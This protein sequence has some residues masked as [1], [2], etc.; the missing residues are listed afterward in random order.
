MSRIVGVD[1]GGTKIAAALVAEDGTI[2]QRRTVA[3]PTDGAATILEAIV[4]L[5]DPWISD[6]Q[7]SAVGVAAAGFLDPDRTTLL[8]APN[9]AWQGE[10]LVEPLRERW[11]RPVVL[12]NDATAA[13]W[14]EASHG[15]GRGI[16]DFMLITIGTGIGGGIVAGGSLVHGGFAAAGEIGHIRFERNGRPCGCGLRGCWEQYASGTALTV[17]LERAG[18]TRDDL[19]DHPEGRRIRD[20]FVDALGEGAASLLAVLDPDVIALGGGVIAGNPHLVEDI[21]A[22]V[23]RFAP[24]ATARAP[25]VRVVPAVLGNDAGLVGAARMV[26]T[27]LPWRG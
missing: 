19:N 27:E 23:H 8:K 1:L 12:G 24:A 15:A 20:D 10:P 9:L 16:Q 5:V 25:R 17:A 2:E 7:A 14:A 3:T 4:D 11:G 22:A 26:R 6:G 18:L 13:A 21:E